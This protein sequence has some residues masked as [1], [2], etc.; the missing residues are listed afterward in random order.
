[1]PATAGK[2]K[3]K[4][5]AA[6]A[7][8]RKLKKRAIPAAIEAIDDGRPT[9]ECIHPKINPHCGPNPRRKYAY[10]P[11]ASGIA[12]PSS[13]NDSAPKIERI[14][15][16]IHAANTIETVLPSRAI[17]AGFRKIPVPIIVPTTIAAEAHGP[18]PRTSSSLFP[19]ASTL[20]FSVKVPIKPNPRAGVSVANQPF[21][22]YGKR[23]TENGQLRP[24][25]FQRTSFRTARLTAAPTKN[26]P[27]DPIKT[28]QVYATLVVLH[29]VT[30]AASP[31][32]IPV[33]APTVFA[34]L[35]SVPSRNNPS[36]LPNGNDATVSPVSSTRSQRTN[37]NAI[38]TSPHASVIRRDIA[39]NF[40]ASCCF[41]AAVEKSRMLEAA[42]EFSDPLAFYIATATIE[43]TINPASPTGISHTRNSGSTRSVRSPAASNGECCVNTYSSTPTSKNSVNCTST[44]PPLV[45]SALRLS[46]SFR[47]ASSRCTIVWSVPWLAMVRNAPPIT[48]D[49][50]VY[51][52]ASENEKSRNCS[53]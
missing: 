41:P 6:T 50:N 45:S 11:P 12:A 25:T 13:A 22:S 19:V 28:Y 49:Q 32:N 2:C 20:L 36:K 40:L 7:G 29:T 30:V 26:V 27:H 31:K 8:I 16:T 9:I 43:A 23:A 24:H 3:V 15:P 35:S 5:G 52:V 10:S 38:S 4:S 33:S 37:P 34:R 39:R 42:S 53:L 17:S 51:F 46:L 18:S 21:F 14:A 44:I 1:M 47:A 48:P